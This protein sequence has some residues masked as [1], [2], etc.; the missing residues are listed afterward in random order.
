MTLSIETNIMLDDMMII[1][2]GAVGGIRAGQTY[3]A[4]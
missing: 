3:S 4:G 1:E 2:C